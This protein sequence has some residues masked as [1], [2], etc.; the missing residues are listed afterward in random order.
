MHG[1]TNCDVFKGTC[2]KIERHRFS[3]KSSARHKIYDNFL[4][5]V[6]VVYL[7]RTFYDD[8]LFVTMASPKY[9]L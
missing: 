9:N 4:M 6:I 1:R 2:D 5:I 3:D 7:T 8:D